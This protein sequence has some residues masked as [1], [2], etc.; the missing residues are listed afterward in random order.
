MHL[1][2]RPIPNGSKISRYENG[3]SYPHS[4]SWS[5]DEPPTFGGVVDSETTIFFCKGDQGHKG[6]WLALNVDNVDEFYKA[7]KT[8]GAEILS[9][10]DTKLW[11]MREMLVK[12]PDGHVL[13]IGH[14]TNCD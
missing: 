8:K 13:R 12:D 6:T 14:H 7:I 2:K 10:P 11:S 3:I 9:P 1:K 5:W 4:A